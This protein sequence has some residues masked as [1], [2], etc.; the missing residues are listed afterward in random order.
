[1]RKKFSKAWIFSKSIRKQRKFR[2]NA[3]LHTRHSFLSAHLSKELRKKYSRRSLPL[4]KGD[5]VYV[6]RG[7]HSKKKAKIVS[8]NSTKSKVS[9]E[10][11][12]QTKKDGTKVN[13]FFRPSALQI[14]SLNDSDKER[15]KILQRTA[16][17]AEGVKNAP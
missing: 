6:M 7:A 11:I 4:R 8:L 14:I 15:L 13:V 3:P 1:M 16:P 12:Q 17:K 5:E 9:L 2:T 10:G